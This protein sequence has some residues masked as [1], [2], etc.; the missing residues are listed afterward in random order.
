MLKKWCPPVNLNDRLLVEG[1]EPPFLYLSEWVCMAQHILAKRMP[2]AEQLRSAGKMSDEV[3]IK[4]QE[5][6]KK[7]E[8]VVALYGPFFPEF[9]QEGNYRGP[10]MTVRPV[11]RT[12][13]TSSKKWSELSPLAC[14]EC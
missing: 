10:E 11:D 5:L 9:D 3:Y 8:E 4:H 14:A 2:H 6:T 7:A 1:M 13:T 12:P